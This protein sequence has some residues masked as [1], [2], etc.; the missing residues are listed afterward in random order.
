MR[1]DKLS[2][3]MGTRMDAYA[4]E[5]LETARGVSGCNLVVLSKISRGNMAVVP[6][7]MISVDS[8]VGKSAAVEAMSHAMRL[9]RFSYTEAVEVIVTD[10]AT[11]ERP[12]GGDFRCFS[13]SGETVLVDNDLGIAIDYCSQSS[14]RPA[15][16]PAVDNVRDS[17]TA[18]RAVFRF[19]AARLVVEFQEGT[20]ERPSANIVYAEARPGKVSAK[21]VRNVL[22]ALSCEPTG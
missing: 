19:G 8:E 9:G 21:D 13:R 17:Y 6:G 7:Q 4:K 12:P 11:V 15:L 10:D 22:R 5:I 1:G 2:C 20:P 18:Q 14:V 16:I 3:Y